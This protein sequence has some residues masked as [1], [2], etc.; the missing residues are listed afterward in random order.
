MKHDV[1]IDEKIK[2]TAVVAVV[3]IPPTETNEI[4]EGDEKPGKGKKFTLVT[5]ASVKALRED[6]HGNTQGL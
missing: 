1:F 5:P 6:K 3:D 2:A 4:T